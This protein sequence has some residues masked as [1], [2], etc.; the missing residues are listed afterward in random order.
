M[1]NVIVPDF[2]FFI[3]RQIESQEQIE[4]C[5]WKLE[6]LITVATMTD[7]FCD[8]PENT[9]RSYFSIATDLIEKAGE[10]NQKSLS[11]LLIEK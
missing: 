6:A 1:A 2:A 3:N 11:R 9:L 7:S 10:A 5:L 8:L 4:S